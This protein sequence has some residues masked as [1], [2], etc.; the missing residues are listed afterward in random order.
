M[1]IGYGY[2]VHRFSEGRKLMLGGVEIPHDK[3]LLGHSDADVLL[4]AITDALLGSLA[5]GDIG[6]HFPDTDPEFKNA[7]SRVL[8]RK[9]Y[10]L[11]KKKGYQLG[12]LDATII[13]E[14]PKLRPYIDDIR[15]TIAEDLGCSID[16]ISV[17]ATTSEKMGFAGREEGIIAQAVVLIQVSG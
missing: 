17:K 16:D 5:L 6:A 7:D 13:A 4:H 1:R 8:L 3:G 2:D 11:I 14:Q 12:N 10:E 9:S 15:K